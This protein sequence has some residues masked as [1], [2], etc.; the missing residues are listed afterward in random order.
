[1]LLPASLL[2]I[3]LLAAPFIEG[4]TKVI[5]FTAGACVLSGGLY[6]LFQTARAKGWVAFRGTS[7]RQFREILYTMYTPQEGNTAMLVQHDNDT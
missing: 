7:P 5:A 6:P 3:C 4:N 1:M 2:L